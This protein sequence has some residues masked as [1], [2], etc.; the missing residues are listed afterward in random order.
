MKKLLVILIALVSFSAF[1]KTFHTAKI[2]MYLNR[3]SLEGKEFIA[4]KDLRIT[5]SS[6]ASY[7]KIKTLIV[8]TDADFDC[9]LYRPNPY[10]A[11]GVHNLGV[12]F[13]H[14]LLS[15]VL[16][17]MGLSQD[18]IT[19]MLKPYEKFP[20]FMDYNAYKTDEASFGNSKNKNSTQIQ[21]HTNQIEESYH[22][23][24]TIM[25]GKDIK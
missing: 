16:V 3:N 6:D 19:S 13:S 9:Q 1:A 2:K 22:L 23:K 12:M 15:A 25:N 4:K 24:I 18:S 11:F 21:L 17:E 7:C 14:Q 8:G 10:P 20:L 5:W